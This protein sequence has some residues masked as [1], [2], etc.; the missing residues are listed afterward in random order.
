MSIHMI[1]LKE[2]FID[3]PE[4]HGQMQYRLVLN[5]DTACFAIH[6]VLTLWHVETI[7][8]ID[9]VGYNIDDA[10]NKFNVLIGVK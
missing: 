9:S 3:L 2:R 5:P 6:T 7:N 8:S 4:L 1:L 10:L